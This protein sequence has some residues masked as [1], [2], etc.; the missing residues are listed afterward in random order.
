M[1]S[2]NETTNTS[3]KTAWL[4]GATGLVG[5]ELLHLLIENH[6]FASV[7]LVSRR[8]LDVP[9]DAIHQS[10]INF[11]D[12][13]A[14]DPLSAPHTV[15]CCLGTT[16]KKAGSKAAF[17]KVDYEYCLNAAQA[18]KEKG[19]EHFLLVSAIGSDKRSPSFYSRTKGECEEAI[20]ELGFK[21]FSI[22]RPSLLIGER[23]E[24]RWAEEFGSKVFS[25]T[26]KLWSGPL[27]P[28]HAISGKEVA[29]AMAAIAKEKLDESDNVGRRVY[30]Y[31]TM[32]KAIQGFK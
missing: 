21:H 29:F 13:A 4:L 6:F 9:G 5:G 7:T 15:F 8:M 1:T 22:F 23:A 31:A 16:R 17:H 28:Y 2:S 10:I 30:S 18:A 12:P 32:Q 14:Y 3:N 20:S 11:D 24:K 25:W 27:E 19:A 26:H